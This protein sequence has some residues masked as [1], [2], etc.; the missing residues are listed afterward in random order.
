M[1]RGA[2]CPCWE[3]ER[4]YPGRKEAAISTLPPASMRPPPQPP[5][6]LFGG[7]P[8]SL[9]SSPRFRAFFRTLPLG[10]CQRSRPLFPALFCVLVRAGYPAAGVR[11][12]P[13]RDG[14]RQ[15]ERGGRKPALDVSAEF[16]P[17]ARPRGVCAP[18]PS[19][20]SPQPSR[21]PPLERSFVGRFR[22]QNTRQL[23][24]PP[25]PPDVWVDTRLG[26]AG[27]GG[28]E[29]AGACRLRPKHAAAAIL[30]PS[31]RGCVRSHAPRSAFSSAR[32]SPRWGRWVPRL[33][34]LQGWG[35]AAPPG[36][37][38]SLD[39]PRDEGGRA[40]GPPPIHIHI[41]V[42]FLLAPRRWRRHVSTPFLTLPNIRKY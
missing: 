5:L 31:A 22:A 14:R 41:P 23:R 12:L 37:A 36:R 9:L 29:G 34:L 38:A 32:G 6:H 17:A 20:P 33:L 26:S 13:G 2:Q 15:P 39:R 8:V 11:G 42:I 27:I 30:P 19:T 4:G 21:L 40:A 25:W 35:Q 7:G 10:S 18:R 28:C 1:A 16:P 24:E 3:R